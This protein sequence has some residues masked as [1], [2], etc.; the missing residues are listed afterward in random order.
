M[1]IEHAQAFLEK[2]QNDENLAKRIHEAQDSE[3]ELEIAKQ[4]GYEF[5]LEELK[6]ASEELSD[7]DLDNVAGGF[8]S[9]SSMNISTSGSPSKSYEHYFNN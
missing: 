7:E 6:K 9:K 4:E 1:S 8:F 3:T 5:D 2:V